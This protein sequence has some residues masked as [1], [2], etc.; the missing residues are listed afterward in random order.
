[1]ATRKIDEIVKLGSHPLEKHF[2]VE[3]NST[4][5]VV[6]RRNTELEEYQEYDTKDKEIEQDY[7]LV[8]DRALDMA[9]KLSEYIDGGAEAKFLARLAEVAAQ[10]LNIALSAAEKKAKLKDTKDKFVHRK[11]TTPGN[12]TINNNNI[13]ITMDRNELLKSLMRDADVIDA[14]VIQEKK[15]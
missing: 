9:D 8:M 7:Q 1:M 6:Y 14:E 10:Q 5:M 13:T 3:E 4:E 15:E 11:N 12:K 2:D